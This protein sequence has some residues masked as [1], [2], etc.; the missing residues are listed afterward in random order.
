MN[1]PNKIFCNKYEKVPENFNW[2]KDYYLIG[3]TGTLA[4]GKST[5]ANILNKENCK[6]INADE[7]AKSMY[8]RPEIKKIIIDKFGTESYLDNNQVNFKYL[9]KNIF[10]N[11]ENVKWINDLIHPLVKKELKNI[12][13][14]S[15]K[16]EIIVYDV[17]LL[18]ESN[19][20]K[21]NDYDLIMVIDAPFEERKLR[22]IKRNNWT[23][24]EF[25]QRENNQLKPELKRKMADCVIWNDKDIHHL[26]EKI[27]YIINN[28]KKQKIL[29]R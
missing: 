2:K 25:M 23:E 18:F 29:E 28:I 27:K 16:G 15:K 9:S 3:L 20:H 4:A 26:E 22:A 14:N 8:L 7:V 21:E 13:S 19:S 12:I 10:S 6:V 24:E 17:P 5:V 11:K 1:N